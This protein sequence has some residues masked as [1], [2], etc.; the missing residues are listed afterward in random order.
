MDV[1]LRTPG[2]SLTRSVSVRTTALRPLV[3]PNFHLLA[4][5]TSAVVLS[6][7]KSSRGQAELTSEHRL[8][9]P[10][11]AAV[12]MRAVSGGVVRRSMSC[13]L[14]VTRDSDVGIDA[15]QGALNGVRER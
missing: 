9:F 14:R 15:R 7:N 4:P 6:G 3:A 2:M 5:T 13:P 11:C 10:E 8:P 12:A 1:S